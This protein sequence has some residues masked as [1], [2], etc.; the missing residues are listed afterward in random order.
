MNIN[1][2]N[3]IMVRKEI[4]SLA[5]LTNSICKNDEKDILS[6]G[7]H[8]YLIFIIVELVNYTNNQEQILINYNYKN[9]LKSVRAKLKPYELNYDEFIK[10]TH[11]M[12]INSMNFYKKDLNDYVKDNFD[13]LITNLGVYKYRG[14]IISNT[15]LIESELKKIMLTDNDFDSNKIYN[16]SKTVGELLSLLVNIYL[17]NFPKYTS[18][19]TNEKIK[20]Y[21]YNV[22]T[23][24]ELFNSNVDVNISL[25]LLNNLSLINYYKLIIADVKIVNSLKYRIAYILYYRTF[26]NLSIILYNLDNKEFENLKYI[27]NE[28]TILDNRI[29]RNGICHYSLKDKLDDSE[30]DNAEM[31]L[32]MIKKYLKI[33]ELNFINL[34]N[35]YFNKIS[36]EIES[37]IIKR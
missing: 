23:N 36:C 25:I 37:I 17:V 8:S 3:T 18:N 19:L 2:L 10:K 9:Q 29:F 20:L 21:D 27:L 13:F 6:M 12:N 16:S 1:E 7:F 15:F 32:G 26:Y 33:N 4:E 14:K 11:D 30:I 22:T 35:D 5:V 28:Y 24:N 31:F 34:L